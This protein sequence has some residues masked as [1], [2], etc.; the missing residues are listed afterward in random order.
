MGKFKRFI[1]L[2]FLAFIILVPSK[3]LA[4]DIHGLELKAV[5]C[6]KDKYTSDV[7]TTNAVSCYKDYKSGLLDTYIKENGD[8][9]DKGTLVI[10]VLSYTYGGTTEV[11]AINSA[12]SYDPDIWVP[13]KNGSTFLSQKNTSAFPQEGDIFEEASWSNQFTLDEDASEVVVSIYE[14]SGYHIAFNETVEL[15][16]FFMTVSDDAPDGADAEINFN[17]NGGNTFMSNGDGDKLEFITENISFEIPGESVSTDA[18]LGS[19][20]VSNSDTIYPLSPDFVV[21]S[22]RTVSC[23]PWR[24]RKISGDLTRNPC[25]KFRFRRK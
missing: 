7:A 18:S 22:V 13:L 1:Y 15:G 24:N 8:K 10:V 12:L 9:I 21:G 2:F 3:T 25:T 14:N 5:V 20:K 16:Y 19:L 23:T 17:T 11:T 6:D 4:A